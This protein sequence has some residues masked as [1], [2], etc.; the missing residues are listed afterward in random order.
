MS[1]RTF[2]ALISHLRQSRPKGAPGDASVQWCKDVA[3]VA[4]ALRSVNPAFD[5][6]RFINDCL[7]DGQ[8]QG[9][10]PQDRR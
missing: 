5:P 6:R 7:N 8:L 4:Q 10:K 9:V 1:R 2:E 3:V